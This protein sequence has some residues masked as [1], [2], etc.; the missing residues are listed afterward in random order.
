MDELNW[1]SRLRPFTLKR[2]FSSIVCMYYN[3]LLHYLPYFQ[4]LT[5]KLQPYHNHVERI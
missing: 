4:G 2:G 5:V 3:S 1:L